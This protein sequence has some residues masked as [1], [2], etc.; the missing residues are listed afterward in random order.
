MNINMSLGGWFLD[1]EA[2]RQ[3]LPVIQNPSDNDIERIL[4]IMRNEAGVVG[5][6]NISAPEIGP[7]E[8]VL[9]VEDGKYFLMLNGY[10]EDGEHVVRTP[11]NDSD[12]KGQVSILGDMYP[13][14]AII[15]NFDLVQDLFKEFAKF[16]NVSLT[17]MS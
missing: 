2:K 1:D 17:L 3:Q 15:S 10:A 11:S 13:S 6:E 5:I 9:Y 7:Y 16:G 14:K 12:S 8:I 4:H